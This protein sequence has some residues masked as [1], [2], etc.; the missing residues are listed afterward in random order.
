MARNDPAE[1]LGRGPCPH[2]GEPVIFK[3]TKGRYVRYSCDAC[4][5]YGYAE[6]GGQACREWSASIKADQAPAPAPAAPPAAPAAA[7]PGAPAPSRK[8]PPPRP[9]SAPASVFNL[10][11]L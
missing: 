11:A 6:E 3:R 10:G 1:R 7:A 5:S 8:T 9:A 2:C 4:Q